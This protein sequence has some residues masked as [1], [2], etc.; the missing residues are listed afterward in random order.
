MFR[1]SNVWQLV[2][3]P[4]GQD[5]YVSAN[6]EID[7]TVQHSHFFPPGSYPEY[8]GWTWKPFSV[9]QRPLFKCERWN[10]DYECAPPTGYFNFQAPNANVSGVFACPNRYNASLLSIWA[11]TSQFNRTDCFKLA[12]L[13]T[14]PYTGPNPPVWAYYWEIERDWLI[15][16]LRD[17]VIG[18]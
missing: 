9:Y 18:C 14:H 4:G 11:A 16:M 17:S 3:V 1:I 8:V 13:G 2:E 12:G 15:D 10:P 5:L 7:I 6:G